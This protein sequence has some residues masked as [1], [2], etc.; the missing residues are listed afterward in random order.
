MPT[1]TYGTAH[2][3]GVSGTITNA[4]VLSF[5]LDHSHGVDDNT[6]NESGQMIE[7][8]YDDIIQEG[9]I[10]LRI[11]ATYTIP[12]IGTVLVYETIRYEITGLTNA[13]E[14]QGFRTITFRIKRSE[15]ITT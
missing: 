11:Q 8:R 14:A 13:Q 4:T 3:Y 7:R 2:L 1:V 15:Y 9:T 6:V 5:S 10:T 12:A